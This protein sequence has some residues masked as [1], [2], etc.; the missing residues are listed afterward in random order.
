MNNP[1]TEQLDV[2]E[3]TQAE[4]AA[5]AGPGSGK[6][7]TLVERVNRLILMGH[8]PGSIAVTTFTNAGAREF[9][10]RLAKRIEE[11]R[12]G[13]SV[14]VGF[15]GTLHAL[16]LRLLREFGT[17]FGYGSRLSM[18]PPEASLD[19]LNSK[20]RSMGYKG[21]L[22]ELEALK[23]AGVPPPDGRFEVKRT[24]VTAYLEDMRAAGVVDYDLLLQEALRML[25]GGTPE[26]FAA[27]EVIRQTFA[28]LFVDEAQ[29]SA[30]ID[31]DIYR[32]FPATSLFVV[33]DPDQAIFGFRGGRV[34]EFVGFALG[35]ART[36]Y[37]ETNF[38][39]RAEI[40]A[41]AQA[42]IQNNHAR[43]K[44]ATVSAKGPGGRVTLLGGDI[45]DAEEVAIVSRGI[46]NIEAGGQSI[47]VL[48]R[49]NEIADGF[50]RGLLAAGVKVAEVK[51]TA[52]P[53]DWRIARAFVELCVDPDND[54]LAFFYLVARYESQ[55]KAPKSARE[56]AH[57]K[58]L[59][60]A[61]KGASINSLFLNLRAI[62]KP[63]I[64]IEAVS[65]FTTRETRMIMAEKL[66]D[67]PRGS[68]ML[69]F[70]LALAEV[71]EF[72]KEQ[73]DGGV[74]VMTMHASKGREFDVVFL[75]GFEDEVCPGRAAKKGP[76]EI[77]EERRLAY[78]AITRAREELHVSSA[79]VRSSK[80][81]VGAPRTPSRFIREMR[82]E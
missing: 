39:S 50:R 12:P 27:R 22:E 41:A 25:R 82:I 30:P 36:I 13:G 18:I 26:A 8:D 10:E 54:A 55:G 53:E 40:C 61:K 73:D 37:L 34:A 47:A 62:P 56:L 42:L 67:L 24:I 31:W 28:F 69:D 72:A 43:L 79:R 7:A 20:A 76:S 33:G 71:R 4:I 77:E 16:C 32:A 57:E 23:A 64:A 60:A 2:I 65:G 17:A 80:W 52:L 59:A 9:R 3:A 14:E 44:K 63:E 29:D 66:A 45:S 19:L 58:R 35:T 51:R 38:R 1:T 46:K 21:S 49:T 5:I 74:R 48:A 68:S 15:T 70:T 81:A 75:V 78:V 6:T 11:T